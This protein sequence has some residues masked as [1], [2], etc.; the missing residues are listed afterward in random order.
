MPACPV[1]VP[2]R[3]PMP[4]GLSSIRAPPPPFGV[5]D[6][7]LEVTH[8]SVGTQMHVFLGHPGGVSSWG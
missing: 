3:G 8:R 5:E 2:L 1:P 7:G 4:S 6:A